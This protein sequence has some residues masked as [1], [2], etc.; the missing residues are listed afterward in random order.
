[1]PNHLNIEDLLV[2]LGDKE[3]TMYQMR[4]QIRG[5]EQ[6]L[7]QV[8]AEFKT[9]KEKVEDV[10]PKVTKLVPKDKET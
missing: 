4:K 10:P 1:M 5:L 6:E 2:L 9:Y 8:K 3:V 7:E